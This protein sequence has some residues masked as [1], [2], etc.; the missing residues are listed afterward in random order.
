[1]ALDKFQ[2]PWE[3]NDGR[4]YNY[5]NQLLESKGLM[6][7]SVD[8]SK[9]K[10]SWFFHNYTIVDTKTGLTISKDEAFNQM[11][12]VGIYDNKGPWVRATPQE[13]AAVLGVEYRPNRFL[14]EKNG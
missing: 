3:T 4:V 2:F 13:V 14:R 1:M 6:I 8:K 11:R 9:S 7:V 5:Y 12:D 10:S